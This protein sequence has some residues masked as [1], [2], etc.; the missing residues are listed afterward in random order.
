M[1]A[2][3]Q[4]LEHGNDNNW[5][6][7]EI[8]AEDEF[9]DDSIYDEI[10]ANAQDF[11]HDVLEDDGDDN[12]EEDFEIMD[13]ELFDDAVF[14]EMEE[15]LEQPFDNREVYV[16]TDNWI[17]VPRNVIRARVDPS[18]TVL[19][20]E[21]FLEREQLEEVE[22]HDGLQQIGERSYHADTFKECVSLKRVEI[23][24]TVT[25]IRDSSFMSCMNLEEV[26]FNEGLRTIEYGAFMG[27]DRLQ[28]I[29]FPST[30]MRI[31]GQAFAD[32]ALALS[33]NLPDDIESIGE[34]AFAN[35]ELTKFRVP[36][37]I[38][39]MGQMQGTVEQGIIT[40]CTCMFSLELSD[41]IT[42]FGSGRETFYNCNSLR[43]ISIPSNALISD[44]AFDTCKDMQQLFFGHGPLMVMA[45]KHRF[46]NLP[47]HKML[48]YQS[49]NPVT[50]SKLTETIEK[51]SMGKQND[52]LGMT[53]LHI[54]ACST[55][56]RLE[57]YQLLVEKYPENLI[58]KDHWG[59][60]SLLYVLWGNAPREVVHFL[61]QS[62][63]SL[64]PNY[65]GGLGKDCRYT[66]KKEE[67]K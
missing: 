22:L 62:Y 26:V 3:A 7:N 60:L 28:S 17:P 49:Y 2:N 4:Y 65:G 41:S 25:R 20:N 1:A 58:S 50:L 35:C 37:S 29:T 10:E 48:Y 53:P 61:V 38:T 56:Q 51:G 42:Q 5:E 67:S 59:A 64:Y 31:D 36:P 16:L 9:F 66:W 11:E 27:C 54:L 45:L 44:N 63:Q 34:G 30:V 55:V 8:I 6:E 40:Q 19:G 23:P 52:C 21:V 12:G 15:Q 24:S 33:I 43:N 46:H 57:L 32:C 13:D 14:D 47:V 18:V 39:S